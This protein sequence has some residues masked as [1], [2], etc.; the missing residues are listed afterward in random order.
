MRQ[1]LASAM[2]AGSRICPTRNTASVF[3]AM[4]RGLC[5]LD[6]I[7]NRT[8]SAWEKL[9]A[10]SEPAHVRSGLMVWE[11]QAYGRLKPRS[12]I[13]LIGCGAGRDLFALANLG[14]TV[15]GLDCSASAIAEAKV[16]AA[17]MGVATRLTCGDAASFVF[18]QP[19]Y[20]AFIFSWR[21]FGCIPDANQRITALR[22]L[23][24]KLKPDGLVILSFVPYAG[25]GR[26]F[27]R[28]AR[29]IGRATGNPDLPTDGD[30]FD[31]RT[32]MCERFFILE[33]LEAEARMAGFRVTAYQEAPQATAAFLRKQANH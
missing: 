4:A 20:D 10:Y 25:E 12:L 22:L 31:S 14:H 27:I 16:Y 33:E 13:G 1:Q 3:A 26:R 2:L 7:T 5:S 24:E 28:L 9:P 32:L 8:K 15:D 29:A 6:Q 30:I 11:Q 17:Q 18:P 19:S 23:S 21:T